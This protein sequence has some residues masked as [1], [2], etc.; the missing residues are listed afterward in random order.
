MLTTDGTYTVIDSHTAGHPT[1]VILSGVPRLAGD[2]VLAM[3]DNFRDRHDHLRARLLHEPAGHAAMVGLVPVPSDRADYG[4]FF[5]SSYVYLDMCGHATIG[6][7]KTLAATGAIAA[8]L[9]SFTL[10]TP[11]GVVTVGL[12]WAPDGSLDRAIIRNVPCYVGYER[13]D[14]ALPDGR[15]VRADLAFGGIWYAIV[16]A[17]PLGLTL[18][19]TNASAAMALGATIKRALGDALAGLDPAKGGASVPSVLFYQET[20]PHRARHLLVLAENKFDRSPC[21]TG[22]SARMALL[23][24]RGEIDD[25]TTYIADNLLGVS[26][27]A[28]IAARVVEHGQPAIIPEIEGQAFITAFSTIV[29]EAGDP[30]TAGFL[31]R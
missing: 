15:K 14:V 13:V 7:A 11:A 3:R 31:C 10:E 20:G 9:E 8:P 23:A 30:L 6:Y 17:A 16:D 22:T 1:R 27:R 2:T 18:D 4:A 25:A 12:R 24:H 28:R 19:D 29:K 21:G 5:I 26:F